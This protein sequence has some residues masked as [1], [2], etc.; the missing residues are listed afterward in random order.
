MYRWPE[1]TQ[2][3]GTPRRTSPTMSTEYVL[4]TATIDAHEGL[5]VGICDILGDFFS[6]N[7]DKDIKIALRGRLAGIMVNIVTQIY[8]QLAIYE[9]GR[10]ILYA[11]LKKALYS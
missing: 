8:R 6:S 2:K 4:I 10:P 1:T 7:M 5:N 9:K 11:T 3:C